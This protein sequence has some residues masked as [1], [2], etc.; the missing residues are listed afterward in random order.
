LENFFAYLE[1]LETLGFFSGYPLIYAL[2]IVIAGSKEK[3][4]GFRS[5]LVR[6]LP[7]AYALTGTLYLGMII[8]N[9]WPS[10]DVETLFTSLQQPWLRVWALLSIFFWLP[11]FGRYPL[12]S[13]FH[14]LVFFY[15]IVRDIIM[16]V[17]DRMDKDLIRN[18]MKVYGDSLLFLLAAFFLL[19][20]ISSLYTGFRKQQ[21]PAARP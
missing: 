7:Y 11:F 3:R 14:S 5:Q 6:T 15:F 4:T 16:F 12:L 19:M 17:S 9:A 13:L 10:V 8:R 18:D 21:D 1:R 2:V 20:A